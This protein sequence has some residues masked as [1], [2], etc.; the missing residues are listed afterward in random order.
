MAKYCILSIDGGGLRGVVPLTMLKAIEAKTG[1]RIHELF[2]FVAGTST[3]G[4]ITAAMSIKNPVD[5]ANPLYTLDDIMDVYVHRGHEIFPER[6][7]LGKLF[8]DAED[9]FKP[10]FSDSG[11]NAVFT[12]VLKNYRMLDCLNDIMV[13][14]YD[15][16]NNLPLFFKS[17][18]ARKNP[19]QNALLFDV[20]R[21]TSAGPSYL[22]SYEFVYPNDTEDPKRNCI[23]GGVFVNNPS[24]AALVEF[25]KYHHDYMPSFP[26]GLEIDYKN[27][28]VLSLGTGSYTGKV[29]DSDTQNKGEIYWAQ[30]ISEIMMRGVNRATDYE[31]EE[32][33]EEGNYL[34]LKFAIDTDEHSETTNSSPE[35]MEYLVSATKEM[36]QQ[37]D[38][39]IN[40]FLANMLK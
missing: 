25:S 38:S 26:D 2:N 40:T 35:T 4:L 22:P 11:I 18:A 15:L 39:D 10:K 13:C 33:M 34:R 19:E 32:I 23:D 7:R 37:R 6:T 20:C 12:D 21:A 5:P 27:V 8:H 9:L 1:K 36:L 16:N 17:R 28:F 30:Q 3:G 29:S 31:M 24:M 14:S